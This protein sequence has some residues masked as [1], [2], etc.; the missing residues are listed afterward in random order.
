MFK[1]LWRRGVVVITTAQLYSTKPECHHHHQL[2]KKD[3]LLNPQNLRRID[4][5]RLNE[6]IKLVDEVTDSEN[7]LVKCVALVIIQL[8]GIKNNMKNKKKEEPFCKR[9]I[10]SNMNALQKDVSLTEGWE[11]GMLRKESQKTR[12]DHLY[13]IKRKGYKR[14]AEELKQRIKAKA[15]TL[16][17]NKNRVK[18]YQQNRLFQS[19]R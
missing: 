13:R 10:E 15:A 11:T 12:L 19:N 8:L 5:V 7:Y 4:R 3:N 9:R 16:K 14:A 1:N 2:M 17:R 6:K 18:Q